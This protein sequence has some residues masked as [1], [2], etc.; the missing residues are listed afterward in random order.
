MIT[1]N[2]AEL[3]LTEIAEKFLPE[4]Q[5][6]PKG[7]CM[8]LSGVTDATLERLWERFRADAP[9]VETYILQESGKVSNNPKKYIHATKLVEL[10]NQEEQALLVLCPAT[11]RTAAEDS[12][13]SATFRELDLLDID[14][15]IKQ[16]LVKEV[17]RTGAAPLLQSGSPLNDI[18][19]QKLN[20]F[21]MR[22]LA[23]QHDDKAIG[24][25]LPLV[26]LLPDERLLKQPGEVPARLNLNRK[27]TTI[28]CDFGKTPYERLRTLPLASSD[29]ATREQLK[30][31]LRTY[32]EAK[33]EEAF[34]LFLAQQFPELDFGNWSLPDLE[35]RDPIKV[36]VLKLTGTQRD[37][38]GD[39]VLMGSLRAPVHLTVHLTTI[40]EPNLV[41][42]LKFFRA[43]L[44]KVNGEDTELVNEHF[45]HW[46]NPTA[47]RPYRTRKLK[48]AANMLESALYFLR[49][50]ALDGNGS[51]LNTDDDFV[52]V[53]A[54]R[55]WVELKRQLGNAADRNQVKGQWTSDTE[56]FYFLVDEEVDPDE[57]R[58]RRT[59]IAT[60]QQAYFR[61]RLDML[62]SSK[63]QE[64][65]I[66]EPEPDAWKWLNE[67]NSHPISKF[68]ADYADSS[69]GYQLTISS[70]LR[71][72]EEALLARPEC[73]GR[74]VLKDPVAGQALGEYA[75]EANPS[76]LDVWPGAEE[77]REE[78]AYFF[79]TVRGALPANTG[80]ITTFDFAG[81]RDAVQRYL[82]TYTEML[83]RL[84]AE[85][86]KW[87]ELGQDERASLQ[88]RLLAVQQLDL[89]EMRG[90]MPS[91]LESYAALLVPPLHPLRLGWQLR[92]LEQFEQWESVTEQQPGQRIYWTDEL[93]ELFTHGRLQP[94]NHPLLVSDVA[95]GTALPYAYAGEICFG[96]GVLTRSLVNTTAQG[97]ALET[98]NR[99]LVQYLQRLLDL[100][101][102]DQQIENDVDE[103]IV[104]D[105]V[106]RYLFLHPYTE[107]LTINI[108]NPGEG[109]VFQRV[110]VRLEKEPQLAAV[111]Y[112]VRLFTGQQSLVQEG[113]A[114]QKLLNPGTLT[115]EEAELFSQPTTNRLFPKLRLSVGSMSDYITRPEQHDAH[116]SFLI[117]P[118]PLRARLQAV[119]REETSSL[120]LG[121]LL[122][123]P[124]I[125]FSSDE[126][127]SSY[128]WNRFVYPGPFSGKATR[129]AQLLQELMSYLSTFTAVTLAGHPTQT[130]PT[131]ELRLGSF[132]TVLLD[133]MHT[134]SDWVVTFDRHLGPELFDLPAQQGQVPFLLDFV[135]GKQFLSV[136]T[137]LTCKPGAE[138]TQLLAPV[139]SRLLGPQAL[140]AK[141]QAF[142]LKLLND[143]RS[144]SGS[145][146]LNLSAEP[147]PNRITEYSGIA[148]A[149][150]L[151]AREGVLSEQFL[152]PLD[153][154]QHLL[155]E[156]GTTQAP[157]GLRRA[158]LL[159]VDVA[160]D[161]HAV[162]LRV[163]EVKTRTADMSS[164]STDSLFEQMGEQIDNTIS[165][166]QARFAMVDERGTA[167]LDQELR[168]AELADL[169]SFYAE[170]A[171]RYGLLA[172]VEAERLK[173]F[174]K[175]LTQT[176]YTLR[177][178]RCGFIFNLEGTAPDVPLEFNSRMF[179]QFGQASIAE[180]L[181]ESENVETQPTASSNSTRA[182]IRRDLTRRRPDP[183]Q[184]E[185]PHLESYSSVTR[186]QPTATHPS[187]SEAEALHPAET[188]P[189]TENVVSATESSSQVELAAPSEGIAAAGLIQPEEAPPFDVYI[190][191]DS[192][193]RQYG[194]LGKTLHGQRIALD[195]NGAQTISLF[196]V[197]GAG[198]SYTVGTIT[199]MVLA[200][201]PHINALPKPLGGVIFHYSR[202]QDYTPEFTAMGVPNDKPAEVARLQD[203][204]GASPQGIADVV[205]VV[206]QAKLEERRQ[207]YPHLQ[208]E[209][210]AFSSAELG[211]Q[212]WQFLMGA[213]G[214]Q[215]LY[216][217]HLNAILRTLRNR[218][219]LAGLQEAI[220]RSALLNPGQRE[221]AL[222]RLTL[223]SEYI[224]DSARLGSLLAP[225]RLLI[226]DLRDEFLEEDD[227][228]G[229]FVLMLNIFANVR[230]TAEGE[231]FNKFIVFDE[232][233]KYMAN[234]ELTS[235]IVTA[236][237]EM[238]H[239]G[240]NLL[241]A[242]QDPPSLP[243]E[244]IALSSAVVLHRFNA[245]S[246]L[247][248]VQKTITPFERLT[249]TDM[250]SLGTGEAFLWAAHS[251][252]TTFKQ[253]PVRIT[254]RPR[255]SKHGG[256]T[257]RATE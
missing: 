213:V 191:A 202:S 68:Q 204:Y 240:V 1:T 142:T 7:H 77:F 250:A 163:I 210:L 98:S 113:A 14:E 59:T 24:R 124:N 239:K 58:P 184:V 37:A 53:E 198:K 144:V 252:N 32:A 241:I 150:R 249:P 177:F 116:I 146:V 114:F 233:H 27:C 65:R 119:R 54:Q 51:P 90:K 82:A 214:N 222:S 84:Q 44:W 40:P 56:Q 66:L 197:Q 79:R 165:K 141:K 217:K 182:A 201:M 63:R 117:N 232:A 161:A 139:V 136:S 129:Q 188:R 155:A 17:R 190:G 78:R 170:R 31:L 85:L 92:L 50:V 156:P 253:Q 26:G 149:K 29:T 193:S 107:Q 104:F 224:D 221:L 133:Q 189:A 219:T 105:H 57:D 185:A 83:G 208:V 95:S 167:R 244:I 46:K 4:L 257:I 205:L 97:P 11:L 157:S 100:N 227:A 5:A 62:L 154:H 174:L 230:K 127:V 138:L 132:E 135:P 80:T 140:P 99:T 194:M 48:F 159:L 158:D 251:T 39:L 166:L 75:F 12:F 93:R 128:S 101:G 134:H 236:I 175:D 143:L 16:R 160:P 25:A 72:A 196:G 234:K 28:L 120:G 164:S 181:E 94:T 169:L 173:S 180:L 176:G 45:D 106:R 243:S 195:L 18:P 153:L 3:V 130:L 121:G 69:Y 209:P 215:A 216:M 10:R 211:I 207:E 220:E 110:L 70:K 245:P 55:T 89:V 86:A 256:G 242:S 91:T 162:D 115:S 52:E 172:S 152:I 229:M 76:V 151:L 200:P 171:E 203:W 36:K 43:E 67:A 73:L 21:L 254:T 112:E 64:T 47:S 88:R 122:I 118:F 2:Y 20:P 225:G 30:K 145:L 237:R 137:F 186:S 246:W 223:A 218:L 38:E 9:A 147:T 60:V 74:T 168:A 183:R 23:V 19:A 87:S 226:V 111:R 206:P 13:G 148:L 131:T 71:R 212:D 125:A 6:A 8:K 248:H 33:T 235:S 123:R 179:Y 255:V 238:R 108:F 15:R 96:W 199:E 192:P 81:Q 187:D 126:T 41:G 61:Y 49:I 35:R 247:K 109:E 34:T 178:H 231:L 103:K 102:T 22:V 42:E 228:L